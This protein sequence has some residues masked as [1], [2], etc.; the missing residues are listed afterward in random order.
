M[1]KLSKYCQQTKHETW[2]TILLLSLPKSNQYH[3]IYKQK[4]ETFNTD[5]ESFGLLI[6]RPLHV[7]KRRHIKPTLIERIAA[8]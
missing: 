7:E 5:T 3:S 4:E 2:Y 1:K 6:R 8:A